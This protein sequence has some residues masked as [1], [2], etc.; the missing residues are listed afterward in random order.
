MIATAIVVATLIVVLA[1]RPESIDK[2]GF[3]FYFLLLVVFTFDF[4]IAAAKVKGK[5]ND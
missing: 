4:V 2:Y 5:K 1:F 3:P